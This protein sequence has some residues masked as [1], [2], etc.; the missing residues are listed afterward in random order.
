MSNFSDELVSDLAA[1][2][3]TTWD[4][5]NSRT[6]PTSEAMTYGNDARKIVAT[7]L[8]ADM[9]DSTLLAQTFEPEVAARVIRSYVN[10]A[11]T[12][13]KRTGGHIRSFDGDRVMGIYIGDNKTSAAARCA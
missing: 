8:Y 12:I 10:G 2:L 9:V 4:I 1:T 13:I 11:A 3:T 5:T 7:Y 6:V